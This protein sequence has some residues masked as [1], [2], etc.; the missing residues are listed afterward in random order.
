MCTKYVLKTN[1]KGKE[2]QTRCAALMLC[3][4]II[5]L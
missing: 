2:K 3:G 1:R 5:V 4:D